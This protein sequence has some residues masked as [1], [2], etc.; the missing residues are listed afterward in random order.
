MNEYDQRQATVITSEHVRLQMT[1]AGVGSRAAALLLDSILMTVFFA[2]ICLFA[3][4]FVIVFRIE[5]SNSLG[6]FMIA[7]LLICAALL[8]GAYYIVMEYYRGGQTFGKKWIGLR[9][10]QEN[11]Q[12]LTFLGAVIRNFFRLIDFLPSFYFLGA[13]WMFFHP[14]DK[15][16]G[17]LAAG[18]IVVR[19]LQQERLRS[20]AKTD[21]WL[22]NWRK[23][24]ATSSQAIPD[25]AQSIIDREDWL[26]LSAFVE[27]LPSMTSRR[28]MDLGWSLATLLGNKLQI[29]RNIYARAPLPFLID[30]YEVLRAEW[31]VG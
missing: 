10:I 1:T 21:K 28:Q 16:L 2:V 8:I 12:P 13:V 31:E 23:Q 26:L 14:M 3:S 6:D 29:D 17:D 27:R 19:D 9:V 20:R 11:G 18:T 5:I 25:N 22:Q 24:W 7:F 15:R 4:L 30:L